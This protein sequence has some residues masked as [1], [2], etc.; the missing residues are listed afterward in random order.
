MSVSP[1]ALRVRPFLQAGLIDFIHLV[2][3]PI[4]PGRG[5]SLWEGSSGAEDGFM[6]ELVTSPSGLTHQLGHNNDHLESGDPVSTWG[7]PADSPRSRVAHQ[8]TER[9]LGPMPA[10]GGLKLALRAAARDDRRWRLR[11]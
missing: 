9:Y 4:T 3:V 1:E 7:S 8:A 10:T 2:I 11:R 6:V 5:V